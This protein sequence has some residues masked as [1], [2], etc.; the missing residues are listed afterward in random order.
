MENPERSDS[1]YLLNISNVVQKLYYDAV[2]KFYYCA[3]N[4]ASI[5]CKKCNDKN[6]AIR[7]I[8]NLIK[9]NVLQK[10]A[11]GGRSTNY[12]KS[13]IRKRLMHND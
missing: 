7:D 6:T 8:N 13:C 5:R 2:P 4:K 1:K 3:T 9:K 10:E 12:P 11:A